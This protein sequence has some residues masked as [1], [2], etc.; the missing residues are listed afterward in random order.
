MM[1]P[2][3]RKSQCVLLSAAAALLLG[4]CGG[5]SSTGDSSSVNIHTPIQVAR[6]TP[7]IPQPRGAAGAVI[8][9]PKHPVKAREPAGTVDDEVN[10]SGAKPL[11]PC[12]LVSRGEAQ[13]ILHKP[14][15]KLVSAPQGPTCI[16][17]PRRS[18]SVITLAVESLKFSKIKPQAQ[19]QDRM[20]V[21][22]SGHTAYCGVAGTPTMILPLPAGRFL[23]ISA[24]CPVAATF[25]AKALAHIAS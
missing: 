12:A 14:V 20:S 21:T 24:P 5:S 16:Y 18:K 19:L 7:P 3:V 6:S 9:T 25:A 15:G 13:A 17:S 11:N 10:S 2:S 1:S 4:A 23:A 22:V 8:A